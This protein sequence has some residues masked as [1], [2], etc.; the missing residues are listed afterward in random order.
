YA[1]I[2][3]GVYATDAD[4]P[5]NPATGL[6]YSV[7]GEPFQAGDPIFR[8]LNGDYILDDNDYTR[9]GNS[10]PL[11][12]GG[13]FIDARYKGFGVS[14]NASYTARRTILN[15]AIAQRLSLMAD[16]YGISDDGPQV[17]VPLD[18]LDMW[19]QPGDIA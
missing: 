8:D 17:V 16:P 5:V 3:D 19:R 1:L 10:Q 9:T 4:V 11:V 7:N 2:N 18:G 13:F 6:R 12:T 15:N 14:F